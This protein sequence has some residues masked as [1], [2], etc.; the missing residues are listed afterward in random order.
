MRL[1]LKRIVRTSQ[2]EQYALFDLD[3]LNEEGLPFSLGKIDLHFTEGATYGTLLLWRARFSDLADEERDGFVQEL[4]DE[5]STPLGVA[6]E[7]LIECIVA[8]EQDYRVCSNMLDTGAVPH[9][10]MSH[11]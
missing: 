6:G 9:Q 5:L 11:S 2:S 3:H 10:A 1:R 8:D 7:Y 4:I